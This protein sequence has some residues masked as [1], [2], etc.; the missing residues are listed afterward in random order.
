MAASVAGEKRDATTFERPRDKSV[1]GIAEGSLHADFACAGKAGHA[2]E[3]AAADDPDLDRCF[4]AAALLGLGHPSIHLYG[5]DFD[6]SFTLSK[7]R[8]GHVRVVH[9]EREPF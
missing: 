3:A 7:I 5:L 2:V 4:R 1:R 6:F 9:E 8:G